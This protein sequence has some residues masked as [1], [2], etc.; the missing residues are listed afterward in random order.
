M[1]RGGGKSGSVSSALLGADASVSAAGEN[2][3]EHP[4]EPSIDEIL[5]WSEQVDACLYPH[6]EIE[7]IELRRALADPSYIMAE[8]GARNGVVHVPWLASRRALEYALAVNAGTEAEEVRREH[9]DLPY[10]RLVQMSRETSA[11]LH[12]SSIDRM[13]R[14]SHPD[15]G[16]AWAQD[17]A[18]TIADAP[19]LRAA[20]PGLRSGDPMLYTRKELSALLGY[21]QR[22]VKDLTDQELR[23]L[24]W[25]GGL[26]PK[27]RGGLSHVELALR[28]ARNSDMN[29]LVR[30]IDG[31]L[32]I[33]DESLSY[34]TTRRVDTPV[35]QR[36]RAAMRMPYAKLLSYTRPLYGIG[37]QREG[38]LSDVEI[39]E[40]AAARFLPG[41][42]PRALLTN[43][44]LADQVTRRLEA[45]R[46]QQRPD[47]QKAY[48]PDSPAERPQ[49]RIERKWQG[50]AEA[51]TAELGQSGLKRI[52]SYA[53]GGWAERTGSSS[54]Y[55][56]VYYFGS[57]ELAINPKLERALHRM[58][59]LSVEE[60]YERRVEILNPA[61]T[62]AHELVHSVSG[63]G[64]GGDTY[65]KGTYEHTIEEGATETLARLRV[66]SLARRMGLWDDER[67]LRHSVPTAQRSE[68]YKSQV[69]TML[70]V[71]DACT[72][73][74]E[75]AVA[76]SSTFAQPEQV[77]Q[78]AI[79][80]LEQLHT[81]GGS[82]VERLDAI[83]VRLQARFGDHV[84]RDEV[85]SL[86]DLCQK[87][88]RGKWGWTH[89]SDSET[90]EGRART[91]RAVDRI[92]AEHADVAASRSF[93]RGL[94]HQTAVHGKDIFNGMGK[95][96]R[97]DEMPRM[98]LVPSKRSS[99]VD[100]LRERFEAMQ[101]G[102]P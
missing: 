92:L 31:H 34:S 2:L 91:D 13:L 20:G 11:C 85:H 66:D 78:A 90:D 25:A 58:E 53:S 79:S 12:A 95:L 93:V 4:G 19:A 9:A 30:D 15:H 45:G 101:A 69:A 22:E 43:H 33:A 47:S 40:Q 89:V 10:G 8:V 65:K 23:E 26:I 39:A 98:E 5:M 37:A 46:D 52:H 55:W 80:F 24:A 100:A 1:A 44:H 74:G 28:Y 77:S 67:D 35:A 94:I 7:E 99:I 50:A 72:R 41:V 75:H 62:L 32:R 83:T 36:L 54:R 82:Y 96:V 27:W 73:S 87:G 60:R 17:A 59:R 81:E 51:F 42:A 14:M 16:R 29:E 102:K 56:G 61:K 88:K 84:S 63:R 38:L 71:A 64:R 18:G 86:L 76:P 48:N 49:T 21:P 57:G 6:G 68:S 3:Y 70:M 97:D